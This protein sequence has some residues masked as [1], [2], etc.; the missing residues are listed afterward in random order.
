VQE[1]SAWQAQSAQ[2]VWL[3]YLLISF[4]GG[5]DFKDVHHLI[6]RLV[7]GKGWAEFHDL[8][9]VSLYYLLDPGSRSRY[10]A[11]VLH[12][13]PV[14][15]ASLDPSTGAII[16]DQLPI[17]QMDLMVDDDH[18]STVDVFLSCQALMQV[19]SF[20]CAECTSVTACMEEPWGLTYGQRQLVWHRSGYRG[21]RL[22]GWQGQWWCLIA[23]S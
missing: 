18:S 21:P 3:P 6:L 5:E 16:G 12:S 7:I 10:L 4:L 17:W 13:Q 14:V 19:V 23:I 15:D 11:W 1:L 9:D 22:S 8:E 20:L 2:A